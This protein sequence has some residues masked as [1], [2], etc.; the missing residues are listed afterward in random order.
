MNFEV[1]RYFMPL[2]SMCIATRRLNAAFKSFVKKIQRL[3]MDLRFNPSFDP[4]IHRTLDCQSIIL[5][6]NFIFCTQEEF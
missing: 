1:K 6:S 3:Y 5:N 2:V 4:L